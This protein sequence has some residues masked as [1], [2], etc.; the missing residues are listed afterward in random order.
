MLFL[1]PSFTL[2]DRKKLETYISKAGFTAKVLNSNRYNDEV[3]DIY[4]IT[5]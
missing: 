4:Y 2:S 1:I 3:I 5:F